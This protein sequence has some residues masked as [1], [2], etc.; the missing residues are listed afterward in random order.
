M[1]V[2]VFV[3][4]IRQHWSNFEEP[5]FP[6]DRKLKRIT[7]TQTGMATE[8]TGFLLNY[9]ASLLEPG[10]CYLEVGTWKGRTL[11]YAMEGNPNKV[12]YACDNFS[13]F[14]KRPR[15]YRPFSE[16]EPR[17]SLQKV[18]KKA[19]GRYRVTFLEGDFRTIL[20]AFRE[21]VGVYFYDGG[22]TF[23]DQYDGLELALPHMAP[24]SIMV[25]DDTNPY[26]PNVN[27]SEARDANQRWL[28]EHSDWTLVFDLLSPKRDVGW[29][30]GIQVLARWS[31][32]P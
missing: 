26:E 4:T 32:R 8:N 6:L 15:W 25:I 1:N 5:T 2:D 7:E 28:K 19:A 13:Q 14:T 3:N 18:L 27:G 21:V 31:G 30:N 17:R 10:E 16:P 23:Q 12:F 20:P 9:A 24:S 11:S 29:H 22:H